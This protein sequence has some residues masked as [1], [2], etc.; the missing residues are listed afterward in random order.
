MP[1]SKPTCWGIGFL[2]KQQHFIKDVVGSEATIWVAFYYWCYFKPTADGQGLSVIV[3]R[4]IFSL[5][6]LLVVDGSW[7]LQQLHIKSVSDNFLCLLC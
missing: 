7:F 4:S 1:P 6:D 5:P 3:I 2:D